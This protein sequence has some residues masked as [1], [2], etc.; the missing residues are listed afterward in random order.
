MHAVCAFVRRVLLPTFPVW[1]HL[2]AYIGT[3]CLY[4]R[5]AFRGW[6]DYR[7]VRNLTMKSCSFVVSL[8]RRNAALNKNSFFWIGN[9]SVSSSNLLLD[10]QLKHERTEPSM[11]LE[12]RSRICLKTLNLKYAKY[13]MLRWCRHAVRWTASSSASTLASFIGQ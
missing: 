7:V 5:L 2:V 11:K 13:D 6:R 9:W 4:M 3:I 1:R 12:K 8:F 10:E